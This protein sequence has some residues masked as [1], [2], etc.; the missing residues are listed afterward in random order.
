MKEDRNVGLAALRMWKESG[1]RLRFR[2]ATGSM[3]PMIRPGDD[4]TIRMECPARVKT[5]DI[6]AY[7]RDDR[8]V[9]HR[10]LQV[11]CRNGRRQFRQ[12]GDALRGRG[13]FDE[14]AFVGRVE[15][16]HRGKT[17]LNMNRGLWPLVNAGMGLAGLVRAWVAMSARRAMQ[18]ITGSG[19]PKA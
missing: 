17:V 18:W 5:G 3:M 12:Q 10:L 16:I 8:V 9:V 4:V 11:R 2:V 19:K 13:C 1:K 6:V 7:I 14:E 15:A